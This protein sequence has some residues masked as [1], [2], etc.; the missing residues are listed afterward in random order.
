MKLAFRGRKA[1]DF[2]PTDQL[3]HTPPLFFMPVSVHERPPL[4]FSSL[5]LPLIFISI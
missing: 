1:F 4:T 5:S 2:I 3:I